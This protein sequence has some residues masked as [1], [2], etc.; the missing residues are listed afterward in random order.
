MEDFQIAPAALTDLGALKVLT[1]CCVARMRELGIEQ[2]DEVYPDEAVIARDLAARTLHGLWG[3]GEIIG[4]VTVDTQ[5]DPLW[6]GLDWSADGEPFAAVHRLMIHPS[7]QGRGLAKRLMAHAESLARADAR[8]S[9]RLD[10]FAAN[11]LALA[12]YQK[13]G[14]RQTGQATMR[15]GVFVGFE[16]LLY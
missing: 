4:C 14:Y 12:L 6:Q 2:W 13:L 11:P 9:I 7:Q 3:G 15:K 1:K 8:R 16:K 10:T 5:A